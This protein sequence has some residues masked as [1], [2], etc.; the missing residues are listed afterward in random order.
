[1]KERDR[2]NE[3]RIQREEKKKYIKRLDT[4]FAMSKCDGEHVN[5]ESETKIYYIAWSICL[6]VSRITV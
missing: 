3:M 6:I 4:L 5:E 2:I 1:M